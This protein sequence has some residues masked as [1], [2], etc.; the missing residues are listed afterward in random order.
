MFASLRKVDPGKQIVAFFLVI[1]LLAIGGISL[2]LYSTPKGLGLNDDAIAYIAGARSIMSGNGY[3]EAWLASNGP[4]T[5]EHK[6]D[7]SRLRIHL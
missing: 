4:V 7:R 1:G 6:S 2:L 5:D 3:R